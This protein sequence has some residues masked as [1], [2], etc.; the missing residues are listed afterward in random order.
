M[1]E[2]NYAGRGIP[3]PGHII[4]GTGGKIYSLGES[5][6]FGPHGVV[7]QLAAQ[8]EEHGAPSLVAKYIPA[9]AWLGGGDPYD[10]EDSVQELATQEVGA[11]FIEVVRGDQDLW[12]L[13]PHTS[14]FLSPHMP[15]DQAAWR[16]NPP[17]GEWVKGLLLELCDLT[18]RFAACLDKAGSCHG[19]LKPSNIQLR[20]GEP[21]RLSDPYWAGLKLHGPFDAKGELV[22]PWFRPPEVVASEGAVEPSPAAD[23]WALGIIAYQLLSGRHPL[24]NDPREIAENLAQG[25]PPQPL[26]YLPAALWQF[27]EKCLCPDRFQR[28]PN[29]EEMRRHL[30]DIP[31]HKEC[32]GGHQR[33][34]HETVCGLCQSPFDLT[35]TYPCSKPVRTS[36]VREETPRFTILVCPSTYAAGKATSF[37]SG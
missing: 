13:M 22:D 4:T 35:W 15:P 12:L 19:N 23:V 5:L 24:G 7:Y 30:L 36:L 10:Y 26:A 17:A 32:Q 37:R 3:D 2:Q 34:Y 31:F 6:A 8:G 9:N 20:G 33:D 29:P 18:A 14:E 11:G 21:F 28:I 1:V 16:E 25:R 27:L